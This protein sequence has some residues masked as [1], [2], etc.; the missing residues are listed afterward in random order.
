MP[1]PIV[2]IMSVTTTPAAT[3][4][5]LMLK[6]FMA[7]STVDADQGARVTTR[8]TAPRRALAGQ[9]QQARR[10]AGH[11]RLHIQQDQCALLR[12]RDTADEA[13]VEAG[14]HLGC[15]SDRRCS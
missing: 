11:Q 9:R 6:D 10:W 1:I 15:G 13:R 4:M 5:C 7:W 2:Q 8:K 12:R 14:S 3:N